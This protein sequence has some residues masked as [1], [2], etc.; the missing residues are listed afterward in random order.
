MVGCCATSK[1]ERN[2]DSFNVCGWQCVQCVHSYFGLQINDEKPSH[3]CINFII[4]IWHSS[5]NSGKRTWTV[6]KSFTVRSILVSVS[7]ASHNFV[8]R[9]RNLWFRIKLVIA[10]VLAKIKR[11]LANT[12][13]LATD[14]MSQTVDGI[15]IFPHS[16][17]V[18]FCFLS[19]FRAMTF[20]WKK[21]KEKQHK[22]EEKWSERGRKK[23]E[24]I[25]QEWKSR[26]LNGDLL[27][28]DW[29]YCLIIPF[30]FAYLT[31]CI[32]HSDVNEPDCVNI[33]V[34]IYTVRRSS[35]HLYELI[36]LIARQRNRFCGRSIVAKISWLK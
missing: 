1:G 29:I 10:F 14:L 31:A 32:S 4:N 13:F 17:F 15:F 35:Y 18:I 28:L 22:N 19:I 2:F 33:G 34:R 30:Y 8:V 24:A 16:L 21:K 7:T 23:I 9:D 25:Y 11:W 5:G 12:C 26:P 36:H 6:Y 3:Y 27:L 20:K